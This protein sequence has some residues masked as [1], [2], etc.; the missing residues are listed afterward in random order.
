MLCLNIRQTPAKIA[1]HSQNNTLQIRTT[2][3]EL[4]IQT[5]PAQLDIRQ[6]KGEFEMDFTPYR[7]SIGIKNL[8]EFMRDYAQEGR[9]AVLEAIGNIAQE[10]D[11]LARIE[12]KENAVVNIAADSCMTPEGQLEWTRIE[13]PIVNYHFE[14]AKIN[15]TPG[16]LDI[17]LRRGTVEN[18]SQPGSVDIQVSQ[19]QSIRFWTTENKYDIQ[20]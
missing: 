1:M 12:S 2:K 11:R 17:T 5:T 19:Y 18:D 8:Q 6:A 3:P 15:V 14:P 9:Q 10:G 13:P 16:K 7:Y 20:A 4:D